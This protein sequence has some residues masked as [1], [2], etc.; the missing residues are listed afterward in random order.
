MKIVHCLYFHRQSYD[1]DM[2]ISVDGTGV[3][4]SNVLDLKNPFFRYTG[5]QTQPPPGTHNASPTESYW[6][7][8][9]V[10]LNGGSVLSSGTLV[11]GQGLATGNYQIGKLK[12]IAYFC[13]ILEDF[14]LCSCH[15]FVYL[16][17]I[18]FA[19]LFLF[20]VLF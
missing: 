10:V 4:S 18:L 17:K 8:S 7:N 15:Y 2:D 20:I 11:S 19:T 9:N 16:I 3:R 1:V 13:F 14:S 5:G 6:N 12:F